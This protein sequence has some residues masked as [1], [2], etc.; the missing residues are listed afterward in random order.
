MK[1]RS[2]LVYLAVFL[3]L[4]L[5]Y[6]YYEVR[7]GAERAEMKTAQARIFN[8][9]AQRVTA[10]RLVNENGEFDLVQDEA[11][12]WKLTKP[13][14]TPAD[15]F[16]VAQLIDRALSSE[17][18]RVF[19]E[20]VE[21]LAQ[22]GLDRPVVS[23][24]LLSGEQPLVP[25]LHIGGRNPAGFLSYGRLGDSREVFTVV[26]DV[27][28][29]LNRK[30]FDLR[31]KSVILFPG[32]KIDGLKITGREAVELKKEDLR[33]WALVSPVQAAADNDVLEKLIFQGLKGRAASF[34]QPE[35]GRDYGF[36][37]PLLKLQVLAAGGQAAELVVGR[38]EEKPSEQGGSEPLAYW[39]R[40]SERPEIM[41]VPA[42]VIEALNLTVF[43]LR[44]RRVMTLDRR[45]VKSLEIVSGEK[46][47][48]ASLFKGIWDVT[49]PAGAVSQDFQI[50]AFLM[51]LEGLRYREK[52]DENGEKAA[53]YGL[54]KPDIAVRLNLE[55]GT[56]A[57]LSVSLSPLENDLLAARAGDGPVVLVEKTYIL[58]HLPEEVR[59][60]EGG[61]GENKQ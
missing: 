37:Q 52:I 20:P 8:L 33:R 57:A 13:I 53:E 6:Y 12:E 27:R 39:V 58:D 16:S 50:S 22:F 40:S 61:T 44:D 17:K 5:F 30:L 3:F 26:D 54:D 46:V 25:A 29:G 10:V 32:E 43:D 34:D 7:L 48:Q 49:E 19:A 18:D 51:D 24:T 41:M 9:E 4:G 15:R 21:D 47:L 55:D 45:F 35:P 14:A 60:P 1:F 28:S 31:D 36:D 38:A 11:G 2:L 23:L 59:P 56:A 42:P